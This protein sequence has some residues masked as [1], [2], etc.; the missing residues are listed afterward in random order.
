MAKRLCS[1]AVDLE[2]SGS[3]LILGILSLTGPLPR[4]LGKKSH[5]F[6]FRNMVPIG[7]CP[8]P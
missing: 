6:V 3:I 5:A 1:V 4:V 8:I 7:I 2:I